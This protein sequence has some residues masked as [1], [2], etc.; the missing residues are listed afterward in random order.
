MRSPD[1]PS[2][3]TSRSHFRRGPYDRVPAVLQR[4][5]A[6]LDGPYNGLVIYEAVRSA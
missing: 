4:H 6:L 5:P 2:G 3:C 1:T